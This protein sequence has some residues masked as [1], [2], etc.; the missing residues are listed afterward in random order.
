M[1][2]KNYEP[3]F[4]MLG[5]FTHFWA[6][7]ESGLTATTT[8]VY[9]LYN[10]KKLIKDELPRTQYRKKSDYLKKAVKRI[11]ALKKWEGELTTLL[12]KTDKLAEDRHLFTHGLPVD[13][14]T[15][16]RVD[17]WF[18]AVRKEDELLHD[19]GKPVTMAEL[20]QMG[21]DAFAYADQMLDL[22]LRI[23]EASPERI[24]NASP[25]RPR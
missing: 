20:S 14:D 10:G 13:F 12:A 15:P 21:K 11:P 8:V 3:Y 18:L 5:K 24:N 1:A 9:R 22:A 25:K 7:M 6:A 2:T 23:T 4:V 16:G 19:K 17:V